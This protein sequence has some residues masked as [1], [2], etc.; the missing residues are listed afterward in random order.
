[1]AICGDV[2][3]PFNVESEEGHVG[4]VAFTPTVAGVYSIEVACGDRLVSGSP[5]VVDVIDPSQVY[6]ENKIPKYLH[7]GVPFEFKLNAGNAG[8]GIPNVSVEDR[9]LEDVFNCKYIED[10][11]RGTLSAIV[12]TPKEYG[13][14]VLSLTWSGS[15]VTGSPFRVAV[16]DPSKCAISGDLAEKKAYLVGRPITFAI[17]TRDAWINDNMK[18]VILARGPSA[19]LDAEIK[20]IEPYKFS[21][22]LI[23]YEVGN[24]TFSIQFGDRDVPKVCTHEKS[25]ILFSYMLCLFC[26]KAYR[27]TKPEVSFR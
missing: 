16:C 14:F 9:A 20:Q 1:M 7:I 27:G 21:A 23:P 26:K 6:L 18:P 10:E 2:Q 12:L 15:H 17:S 3:V 19:K 24:H 11:V 8:P 13:E 25:N 4:T 5:F 22:T